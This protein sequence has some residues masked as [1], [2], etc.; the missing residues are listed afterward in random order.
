MPITSQRLTPGEDERLDRINE[1]LSLLQKKSG[2]TFTTDAYLLAAFARS[3]PAGTLADLGSGTGVAALLCLTKNKC[4]HAF[5][6]EIQGEFCDLIQ[7]NAALNHLEDRIIVLDSGAVAEQGTH[8]ELVKA[9]GLYAR[10]WADYNQAVQ[11]KISAEKEG[12]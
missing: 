6:V 2:L 8:E 11:W 4:N 12:K 3:S 10:M 9:N 1:N 7:R 5:A